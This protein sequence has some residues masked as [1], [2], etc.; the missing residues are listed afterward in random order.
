MY[1]FGSLEYGTWCRKAPRNNDKRKVVLYFVPRRRSVKYA[2]Q[3]RGAT[4]LK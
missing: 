4:K 2:I 3:R 1:I